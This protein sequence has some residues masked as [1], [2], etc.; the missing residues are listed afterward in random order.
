MSGVT[1]VVIIIAAI[2]ATG[3]LLGATSVIS[4]SSIKRSRQIWDLPHQFRDPR[5]WLPAPP[6]PERRPVAEVLQDSEVPDG[7]PT[8]PDSGFRI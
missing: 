6:G 3:V 5:D 2:F 7:P 1:I 8:W 4:L